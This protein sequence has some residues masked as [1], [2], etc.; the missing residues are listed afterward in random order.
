MRVLSL[1]GPGRVVRLKSAHKR[2]GTA[3]P[4]NPKEEEQQQQGPP[5]ADQLLEDHLQEPLLNQPLANMDGGLGSDAESLSSLSVTDDEDEEEGE[6]PPAGD[7]AAAAGRRTR[8][9]AS[10]ALDKVRHEIQQQYFALLVSNLHLQQLLVAAEADVY[11]ERARAPWCGCPRCGAFTQHSAVD[12]HP[13]Q[14]VY[15]CTL[16][17]MHLLCFQPIRCSSCRYVQY[18]SPL[19]AG[20]M[21]G[22]ANAMGANRKQGIPVWFS[23]QLLRHADASEL[24]QRRHSNYAY[25]AAMECVWRSSMQVAGLPANAAMQL[26]SLP[27]S[28][29]RDALPLPSDTLRRQLAA[30]LREWRYV[31]SRAITLQEQLPDYP[32]GPEHPCAACLPQQMQLS[33][34]MCFKLTLLKRKGYTTDYL[35]PDNRRVFRLSNAEL[36][37]QLLA[38]DST[39][40]QQ[41]RTLGPEAA[42]AL[43]EP[44]ARVPHLPAATA[45]EGE[46]T[47]DA[48]EDAAACDA[49]C[50]EFFHA[51]KLTAPASGKVR[52][53]LLACGP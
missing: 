39:M 44:V 52:T 28:L 38:V 20:C 10:P 47:Q 50:S 31:D 3:G 46:A 12:A 21:P 43:Q 9:S 15:V 8:A 51:D 36:R 33:F 37:Q 24:E 7:Q 34:D 29:Q 26:P 53:W 1:D 11:Q 35:Q 22:T 17:A 40:Q 30:A 13:G 42:A 45:A 23:M 48:S 32:T 2:R 49:A 25:V 4:R 14:P 5:A 27:D 19:V 18:L 16:Q 6:Q 41:Q